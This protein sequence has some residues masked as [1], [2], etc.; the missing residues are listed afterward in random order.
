MQLNPLEPSVVKARV[1]AMAIELEVIIDTM[2]IITKVVL[3]FLNNYHSCNVLEA[4]MGEE[5]SM[6][7]VQFC[8]FYS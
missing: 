3:V 5:H 7:L 4:T 2:A 8:W 1:E 6:G